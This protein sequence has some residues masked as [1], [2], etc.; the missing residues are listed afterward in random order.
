M[1]ENL[2]ANGRC[3]DTDE[4]K[5]LLSDFIA[6]QVLLTHTFGMSYLVLL[7]NVEV[8]D[9]SEELVIRRRTLIRLLDVSFHRHYKKLCESFKRVRD[10]FLPIA[11]GIDERLCAISV[12][13]IQ[14]LVDGYNQKTEMLQKFLLCA[15]ELPML[16]VKE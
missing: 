15:D 2:L 9:R 12:P 3:S 1:I 13:S 16:I 10:V 14:S 7:W 8:A 5:T 6:T 4:E 11:P